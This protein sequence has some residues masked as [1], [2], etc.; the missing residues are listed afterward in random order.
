MIAKYSVINLKGSNPTISFREAVAKTVYGQLTLT[1]PRNFRL[2]RTTTG[3]SANWKNKRR[4][5]Y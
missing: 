2:T 5:K 3:I 4:K 1:K